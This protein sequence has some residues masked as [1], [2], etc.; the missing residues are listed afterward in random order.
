MKK[1][2]ITKEDKKEVINGNVKI[3]PWNKRQDVWKRKDEII[4][5]YLH[6]LISTKNIAKLFGCNNQL[7]EDILRESNILMKSNERKIILS[8]NGILLKRQDVWDKSEE[9]V[10]LYKN[11]FVSPRDIAD[12]LKCSNRLI[13]KI[14]RKN[15]VIM[16]TNERLK[17]LC[18]EGVIIMPSGENHSMYGKENK[19]GKHSIETKVGLSIKKIGE[20]N[21]MFGKHPTEK[22]KEWR[23]NIAFPLKDTSIEIKIQNFL[24]ELNIEFFT[25]Q[26]IKDIEHGYQC[27]IIVPSR[28]LII[29]CDGDYWHANPIFYPNP[30]T[31]QQEQISRDKI[32]TIELIANGFKVLRLWECDINKMDIKIFKEKLI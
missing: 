22:W 1:N 14:L 30:T 11:E 4:N 12:D 5:M 31:K 8:K 26:Y 9:I 18:K 13:Y 2:I 28:N 20:K 32:R 21:P 16:E 10:N 25:H 15:S 29:E 19:W 7:I 24:K 17:L 27:D 6:N 23:K 3:I